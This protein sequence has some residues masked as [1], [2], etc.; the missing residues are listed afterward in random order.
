MSRVADQ[1]SGSRRLGM[2]EEFLAAALVEGVVGSEHTIDWRVYP[3]AHFSRPQLGSKG[4]TCAVNLTCFCRTDSQNYVV[5]IRFERVAICSV[6]IRHANYTVL[7][8]LYR[9]DGM[10]KF[11]VDAFCKKPLQIVHAG[12]AVVKSKS[13]LSIADN[14]EG[15]HL[16]QVVVTAS[17]DR[18]EQG[19]NVVVDKVGGHSGTTK[20]FVQRF[21]K[22][23]GLHPRFHQHADDRKPRVPEKKV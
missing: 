4:C 17:C 20:V 21:E 22:S 10:A 6:V 9:V 2:Q 19:Q 8:G 1:I 7:P 14:V 3:N 15:W 18:G 12:C 11:K 16:A 23:V 13:A 5:E